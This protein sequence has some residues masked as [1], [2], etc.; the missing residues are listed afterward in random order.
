MLRPPFRH[1]EALG[2]G[3]AAA[4]EQHPTAAE[5]NGNLFRGQANTLGLALVNKNP[6]GLPWNQPFLQGRSDLSG[7][8]QF[9]NS[10]SGF[11]SEG[12][13]PKGPNDQNDAHTGQAETAASEHDRIPP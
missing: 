11:F 1:G 10:R 6:D 2:Y 3:A 9:Q 7:Q 12:H 13:S 5:V 8:P 4:I